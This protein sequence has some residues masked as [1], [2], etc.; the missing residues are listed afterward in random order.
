MADDAMISCIQHFRVSSQLT[1]LPNSYRIGSD[2][3]HDNCQKT[4]SQT[5]A[6]RQIA[7]T[8]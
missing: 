6:Y 2:H 4:G 1:E 3:Q 5:Y 8:K 7:S